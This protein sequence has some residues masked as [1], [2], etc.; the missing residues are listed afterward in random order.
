[1]PDR[2]AFVGEVDP[3]AGARLW[4][5]D[6]TGVRQR[7]D[8]VVQHSP[9][10]LAWGYAGKGPADAALSILTAATGD[11]QTAERLHEGF[12]RDV[13]AKLPIN[14]RFALPAAQVETWL[15]ANGAELGP[16]RQR[17]PVAAGEEPDSQ[18]PHEDFDQRG[19]ALAARARAL[20]ERERRLL[21][22]E[23]RV[24]AMAVRVGLAAEVEPATCLPAGPVRHHLEALVV[25]TGDNIAE[26]ARAN[27][28]DP[29]WAAAVAAGTV[30]Q[31][32]VAHVRHVCEGL[33][34]TPYDL[35][36]TEAARSI[37]HAYG[38]DAWPVTTEPLM[39]VDGA[40]A[41]ALAPSLDWPAIVPAAGAATVALAPAAPEPMRDLGPELVP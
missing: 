38:P 25:D 31:L 9:E 23:V 8:H 2:R 7:V 36:G 11:R 4:F 21:E 1:M 5:L 13:L 16:S 27:G 30:T 28:L 26:V 33:R 15:G 12:M 39:P 18:G 35:W 22:R 6:G 19:A 20:D 10:G 34:C 17:R 14:E 40:E 3:T 29:L 41:D 32:D 37:S 24:D